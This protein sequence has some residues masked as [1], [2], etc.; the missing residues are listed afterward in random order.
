MTNL[1]PIT[2]Q[3]QAILRLIYRYRYLNRLQVQAFLAHSD[4]RRSSRWLK[5]LK[6]KDYLS[7]IYDD[8]NHTNKNRPAVYF[9]GLSGI[10]WLRENEDY[11]AEELRKRYKDSSRRPDFIAR[12]L[13]IAVCCLNVAS[14]ATSRTQYTYVTAADYLSPDS[15]YN[16]LEELRPHLFISKETPTTKSSYLLEIFDTTTPRYMVKKRLKHYLE[17][18]SDGYWEDETGDDEPPVV[19]I[20]CPGG[21]ELAYANRQ[22]QKLLSEIYGED[23]PEDIIVS[24]ATTAQLTAEGVTSDIWVDL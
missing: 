5:D 12:S 1:P 14:K 19:L 13:V 15:D 23:I 22:T 20:A 9:M 11:P 8:T 18:L 4:K 10:R 21:K 6:E 3:Q 24:F 7:W 17:Y 16:F 2:K